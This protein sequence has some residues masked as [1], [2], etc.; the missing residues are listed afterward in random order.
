MNFSGIIQLN[1]VNVE[2]I[3]DQMLSFM[4]LEW[5]SLFHKHFIKC[6]KSYFENTQMDSS[7]CGGR[8]AADEM[9]GDKLSYFLNRAKWD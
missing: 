2:H 5:R 7:F 6:S 3:W 4:H 9:R 8:K 1:Q